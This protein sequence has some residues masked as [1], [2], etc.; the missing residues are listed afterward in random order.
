MNKLK[1][2]LVFSAFLC[3][4][5]YSWGDVDWSLKPAAVQNEPAGL[6]WFRIDLM[7]S[8]DNRSIALPA[9]NLVPGAYT[10]MAYHYGTSGTRVESII[11]PNKSIEGPGQGDYIYIYPS[12]LNGTLPWRPDVA[13]PPRC[14]N[15]KIHF[16]VEMIAEN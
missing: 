4:S 2:I 9:L 5:V 11:G 10:V 3:V 8:A 15:Y 6:Q 13:N 7:N 14:Y 16:I 12:Y 1:I